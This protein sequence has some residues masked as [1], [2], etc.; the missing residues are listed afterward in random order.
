MQK[1]CQK[2][3]T[4]SEDMLGRA[5]EWVSEGVPERSATQKA[6]G[7]VAGRYGRKDV[8]RY[9]KMPEDSPVRVP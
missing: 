4:M 3:E 8:R 5:P 6:A 7:K 1:E 2:P 9:A